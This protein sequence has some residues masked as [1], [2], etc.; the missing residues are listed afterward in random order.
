MATV[1]ESE[2]SR[3]FTRAVVGHM[4][5]LI[6]A[7]SRGDGDFQ[8]GLNCDRDTV[9]AASL[10][11]ALLG[12]INMLPACIERNANSRL[13]AWMNCK[14]AQ[15]SR[16]DLGDEVCKPGTRDNNTRER[17]GRAIG[18]GNDWGTRTT[19][20]SGHC[21][22]EDE[23]RTSHSVRMWPNNNSDKLSGWTFCP[24][25]GIFCPSTFDFRKTLTRQI[26]L[27]GGACTACTPRMR[28]RKGD[29]IQRCVVS[30][31]QSPVFLTPAAK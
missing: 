22:Q 5:M 26:S 21:G 29:D 18:D 6:T 3:P 25:P 23:I 27:A 12:S 10:E 17:V 19:I 15:R 30:R 1:D 14:P 2:R 24:I 7:Q 16:L 13:A 20:Q 9:A 4:V 11:V 8:V 28:S 31:A